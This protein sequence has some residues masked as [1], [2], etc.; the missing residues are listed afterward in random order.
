MGW[1]QHAHGPGD[2]IEESLSPSHHLAAGCNVSQPGAPPCLL[3]LDPTLALSGPLFRSLAHIAK[4]KFD[5]RKV[6][7]ADP[8]WLWKSSER[9][10]A[11]LAT[12]SRPRLVYGQ[13]STDP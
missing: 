2:S 1:H 11:T 8:K 10:A 9:H 12:I 7:T 6:L 13:L 3:D 4:A 5:G